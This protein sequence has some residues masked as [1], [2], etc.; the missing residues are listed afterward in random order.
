MSPSPHLEKEEEF[1]RKLGY[2]EPH[3]PRFE[4]WISAFLKGKDKSVRI[5]DI[6]CA[7]GNVLKVLSDGGFCNLTGIEQSKSAIAKAKQYGRIIRHDLENPLPLR[8]VSFD[9]AIAK[10]VCEHIMRIEQF[11]SEAHRV[12][13]PGGMLIIGGPNLKSLYHRMRIMLGRTSH[14]SINF[15]VVHVRWVSYDIFGKWLRPYFDTKPQVFEWYARPFPTLLA[16]SCNI[17]CIKKG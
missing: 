17:I 6:G 11:I 10:D 7:N 16:R 13:K 4:R 9:I 8:D 12:L 2:N 15:G 1:S 14:T 3:T 5:L